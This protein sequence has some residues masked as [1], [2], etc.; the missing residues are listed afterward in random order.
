MAKKTSAGNNDRLDPKKNKSLAVRN[1]LQKMP[2]AKAADVVAAVKKE[3]GHTIGP[4]VVYMLKTKGNMATDGRAKRL[5]T[6]KRD[7]PMTTPA[8][9]VEAIKM[10]RSLLEATG[11]VAN[12]TAL[13]RALDA[14]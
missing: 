4:N 10:A 11:S 2:T 3:Y 5:K 14:K 12:A 13:L 6:D 1:V 7:N 9:W 8:L